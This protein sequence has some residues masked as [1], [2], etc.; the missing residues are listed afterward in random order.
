MNDKK[1]NHIKIVLLL[2]TVLRDLTCV[3]LDPKLLDQFML[4]PHPVPDQPSVPH[5]ILTHKQCRI[6][7][8][9]IACCS[10]MRLDATSMDKLWDLMVM[11]LKWQL[12][13]SGS[14]TQHLLDLTFRHMDGIGRLLPESRKTTLIDCTKRH[15]IEYWD[16][17]AETDRTD[18]HKS[19]L[20]WLRPFTVKISILIR[21][22]FQRPDASFETRI[23]SEFFRYYSDHLGENIYTKH[24]YVTSVSRRK[25]A[26]KNRLKFSAQ[27]ESENDK[28]THEIESLVSQLNVGEASSGGASDAES[29]PKHEGTVSSAGGGP[30]GA[31]NEA[32]AA[33][34]KL[35][36]ENVILDEV[37]MELDAFNRQRRANRRAAGETIITIGSRDSEFEHVQRTCSSLDAIMERLSLDFFRPL[38]DVGI[39]EELDCTRELLR[40]LDENHQ[41]F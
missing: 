26:G 25:R 27:V 29:S 2:H 21:L 40:L 3:L 23:D 13:L 11:V 9:D 35:E 1:S 30:D 37:R 6:L 8:S 39:C 36:L 38:G 4:A 18:C 15:L 16:Q 22:G 33:L 14:D 31:A 34:E 10:L 12:T 19:L 24:A 17:M 7:L 32:A 20:Q 28:K 41:P 5:H